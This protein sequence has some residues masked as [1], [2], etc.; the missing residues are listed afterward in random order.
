MN[1]VML[2]MKID[3]CYAKKS[4]SCLPCFVVA[5]RGF[6]NIG[7]RCVALQMVVKC[8]FFKLCSV[9]FQ[10]G[11]I[12]TFPFLSGTGYFNWYTLCVC[13]ACFVCTFGRFWYILFVETRRGGH[14]CFAGLAHQY[15]KRNYTI[16]TN[17]N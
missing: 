17:K 7:M 3:F 14:W 13:Q 4:S 5:E 16:F 8:L 1:V 9:S 11:S 12:D 10:Y 2:T 6:L 15:E